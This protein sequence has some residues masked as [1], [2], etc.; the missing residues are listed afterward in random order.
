MVVRDD[1][2]PRRAFT[3]RQD[4]AAGGGAPGANGDALA[5]IT[6]VRDVSRATTTADGAAV[7]PGEGD[8]TLGSGT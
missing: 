2:P 8:K 7:H 6:P 3:L 1:F 4:R 5:E